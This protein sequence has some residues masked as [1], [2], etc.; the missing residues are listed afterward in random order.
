MANALRFP[1]R[2]TGQRGPPPRPH[3]RNPIIFMGEESHITLDQPDISPD[4]RWTD[5]MT[6]LIRV[7]FFAISLATI[8]P[9]ANAAVA[10]IATVPVQQDWSNG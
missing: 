9:V 10:S 3:R 6:H 7:A 1:S 4:R 8:T 2:V 5:P